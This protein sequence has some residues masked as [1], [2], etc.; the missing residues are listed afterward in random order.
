MLDDS[1]YYFSLYECRNM[2]IG[3]LF[4]LNILF[5]AFCFAMDWPIGAMVAFI[6]FIAFAFY[7]LSKPYDGPSNYI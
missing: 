2:V 4:I 6:I 5:G 3:I 7:E 1:E